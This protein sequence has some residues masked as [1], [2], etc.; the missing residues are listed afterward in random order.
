MPCPPYHPLVV[1]GRYGSELSLLRDD[2]VVECHSPEWTTAAA[3]SLVLGVGFYALGCPFAAS[4]AM[5]YYKSRDKEEKAQEKL[6]LNARDAIAK[7][8][9]KVERHSM[10]AAVYLPEYWYCEPIGLLHNFPHL[11]SPALTSSHLLS[12]SVP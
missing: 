4:Y 7:G 8:S 1:R 10:L 5:Q 11:L 9:R 12:P 3:V 2:P 6:R